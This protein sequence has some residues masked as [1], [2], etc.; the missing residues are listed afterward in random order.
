MI[1]ILKKMYPIS[2]HNLKLKSESVY[3]NTSCSN[4]L[5]MLKKFMFYSKS[6]KK[7]KTIGIEPI[8][9]DSWPNDSSSDLQLLAWIKLL[10]DEFYIHILTQ[11]IQLYDIKEDPKCE[12]N[13]QKPWSKL[14]LSF[15]SFK[16]K[17]VL[18]M[19]TSLFSLTSFPL[20]ALI[21]PSLIFARLSATPVN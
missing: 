10:F 19:D 14:V 12:Y 11:Q 2:E 16:D 20:Q 13:M 18:L 17:E 21:T 1:S 8:T 4:L 9:W 15:P 3:S 6:K 7:K 5:K